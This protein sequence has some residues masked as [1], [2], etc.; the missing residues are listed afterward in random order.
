MYRYTK[1]GEN[2]L[3]SKWLFINEDTVCQKITGHIYLQNEMQ[4]GKP[5]K[6]LCGV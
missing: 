1:M 3:S 5:R 2:F 4:T 6:K